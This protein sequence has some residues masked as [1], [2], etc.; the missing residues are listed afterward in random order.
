MA[1]TGRNAAIFLI[2]QNGLLGVGLNILIHVFSQVL[3]KL[4]WQPFLQNAGEPLHI[5]IF[6]PYQLIQKSHLKVFFQP[7]LL[8]WHHIPEPL[9]LFHVH[10]IPLCIF[11]FL[12]DIV[13]FLI[14]IFQVNFEI[15]PLSAPL[16]LNNFVMFLWKISL[17]RSTKE[18]LRMRLFQRLR[19]IF[20]RRNVRLVRGDGV[21]PLKF[22]RG[23][24]QRIYQ[25]FRLFWH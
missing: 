13:N 20:R 12:L 3:K 17:V 10:F 24:I 4:F 7:R 5:L 8:S 6:V 22:L 16:S 23:N 11:Q 15:L 14:R 2:F 18:L 9:P 21:M 25:L 19:V 1:L